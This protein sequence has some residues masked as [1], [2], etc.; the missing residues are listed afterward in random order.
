MTEWLVQ[1]LRLSIISELNDAIKLHEQKDC[2]EDLFGIE[3]ELDERRK[4]PDMR[5]RQG[6]KDAIRFELRE[7]PS[8]VDLFWMGPTP[9]EAVAEK[10][11][12]RAASIGELNE[13]LTYFLEKNQDIFSKC[14]NPIR[15]ALGGVIY[16]PAETTE[17]CYDLMQTLVPGMELSY[18]KVSD[19]QL[20]INRH[21][22]SNTKPGLQIN[23]LSILNS[24]RSSVF[25]GAGAVID[26][27]GQSGFNWTQ[28]VE[29][30][31]TAPDNRE[32]YTEE[33]CCAIFAE[34]GDHFVKISRG[35]Y[36]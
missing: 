29:D 36:E 20:Q 11:E 28:L 6:K 9:L 12:I 17:Q 18:G 15:L 10:G 30:L 33:E 2:F 22:V 23:R 27:R 21:V 31:N 1:H 26:D 32:V 8:R 24:Q 3:P 35:E 13:I 19:F 25:F 34:L 7:Q 16:S 4:G 5:R 14:Q